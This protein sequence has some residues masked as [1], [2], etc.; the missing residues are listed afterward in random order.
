MLKIELKIEFYIKLL[1]F[2]L[3][4]LITLLIFILK[5]K[6]YENFCNQINIVSNF[7]I[8]VGFYSY[9]LKH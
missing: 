8:N 6:S 5:K 4:R 7:N 9:D 2:N 3:F 1:S